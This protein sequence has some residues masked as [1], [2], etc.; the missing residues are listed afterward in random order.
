[1]HKINRIET[2]LNIKQ[3]SLMVKNYIFIQEG[4]SM[5]PQKLI[6]KQSTL[7]HMLGKLFILKQNIK[8]L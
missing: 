3:K 8:I 1:M 7:K 6:R 5:Y 2:L 4:L